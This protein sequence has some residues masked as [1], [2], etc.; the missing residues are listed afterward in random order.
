MIMSASGANM[1]QMRMDS[2]RFLMNATTVQT[3]PLPITYRHER[4]LSANKGP[5]KRDLPFLI[6]RFDSEINSSVAPVHKKLRTTL[7]A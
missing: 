3:W 6:V 1:I 5:R 2:D 4:Y 7:S